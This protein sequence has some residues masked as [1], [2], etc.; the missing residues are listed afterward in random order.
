MC[1]VIPTSNQDGRQAKN[2]KGGMKL[3]KIFSSETTEPI[4]TN[5]CSN[6]PW[7]VPF[8]NCV[9]QRGPASKKA[10]IIINRFFS[11]GQTCFIL[12]QKVPTFELHKHNDE[13]FN[14]YYVIFNEL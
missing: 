3:K 7:V 1:P 11:N 2:K 9:R 4:S 5:L 14:T 10:A 8:Q 13:L 6:D 12:S